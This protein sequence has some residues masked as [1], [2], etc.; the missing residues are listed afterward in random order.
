MVRMHG[1]LDVLAALLY[2]DKVVESTAREV[3][4][5]VVAAGAVLTVVNYCDLSTVLREVTMRC[6]YCH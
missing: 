4:P 5:S 2:K 6:L 1:G 3:I